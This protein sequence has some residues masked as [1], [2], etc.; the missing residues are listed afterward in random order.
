MDSK[1]QKV[2]IL[3]AANQSDCNL[4][5]TIAVPTY[6]HPEG[7][8]RILDTL[9]NEDL[10][11]V[12]ILVGDDSG[13]DS[14]RLEVQSH[15]LYRAGSLKYWNNS[16]SLGAVQNWNDLLLR[17]QGRYVVLMHHDESPLSIDFLSK[18]KSELNEINRVD[19]LVLNCFLPAMRGRRLRLHMPIF[20]K[21]FLFR[22]CPVYLLRHNV[23]GPT[24]VLAIR[25]ECLE[26]FDERLKWSVDVEWMFRVL[27]RSGRV[28]VFSDEISILSTPHANSITASLQGKIASLRIKEAKILR[29]EAGSEQFIFRLLA[30]ATFS[31]AVLSKVE[32]LC[33]YSLRA[34]IRVHGVVFSRPLPRRTSAG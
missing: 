9:V 24:G 7:V 8:K 3:G 1:F 22:R 19:V 4:W 20:I 2:P 23:F 16:P 30:P 15:P 5:L 17:A 6:E 21:K 27:G 25:R 32:W 28:V 31:M 34:L 14:V 12:E 11:G 10:C 29:S 18:L 13:T 33:W 26:P